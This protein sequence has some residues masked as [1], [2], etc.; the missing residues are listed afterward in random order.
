[1]RLRFVL[2]CLFPLALFAQPRTY[3]GLNVAPLAVGTFDLRIERQMDPG[4]NLQIGAGFRASVRDTN[5]SAFFP[6]LNR[7]SALRNRGGFLSLGLRVFEQNPYE[8]PYASVD[9]I[10]AYYR[11]QVYAGSGLSTEIQ[12][13]DLGATL[14][15]GFVFRLF[16]RMF[17]DLGLQGGYMTPRRQ[18]PTPPDYYVPGAGYSTFG[19]DLL[20]IRGLHLQPVL[21]L[22]YNLVR[23]RRDLI[24]EKE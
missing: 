3:V 6:A 2:L 7:F 12:G 8:F 22:K 19:F 23:D 11:E 18:L 1:M 21:T 16:P 17:A 24:R 4:V 13:F 10:A 9:V 20:S 14:T 15:L 5:E